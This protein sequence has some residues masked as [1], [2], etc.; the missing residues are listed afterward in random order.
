MS[1]PKLAPLPWRS[2]ADGQHWYVVAADNAAVAKC[3]PYRDDGTSAANLA[4]LAAAPQLLAALQL[5]RGFVA[6]DRASFADSNAFPDG[7]FDEDD[8]EVI[9]D[10]DQALASIDAALTA[11]GAKP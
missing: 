5:A 9:N 10:Y 1:T 4:L 6:T 7:T 11:A 2:S 8:T 3:V